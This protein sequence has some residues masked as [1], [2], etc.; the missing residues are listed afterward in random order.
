MGDVQVAYR[1]EEVHLLV[2][3]RYFNSHDLLTSLFT[4]LKKNI[5]IEKKLERYK[6][7]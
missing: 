7:V 3:G 6:P 5:F 2:L 1:L 4:N